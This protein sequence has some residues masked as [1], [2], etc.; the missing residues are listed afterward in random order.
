MLSHHEFA[1]LMLVK[2]APEQVE[3]NRPDL[4]SLLESKLIEWEELEPGVKSPRLTVQGKY[5]LQAVA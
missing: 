4:E 1:T 5:V 2:D 3:L